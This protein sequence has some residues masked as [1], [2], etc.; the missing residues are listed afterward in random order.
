MPKLLTE[1][2]GTFFLVLTI[3]LAVLGGTLPP[4]IAPIGIAAALVALIYA[5]APVSGAHYNPAVTLAFYL[6]G[7]MTMADVGRYVFAQLSGAAAAA[8]VFELLHPIARPRPQVFDPVAAFG[9]EALFTFALVWV[10]LMV[11]L[12]TVAKDNQYFGLAIGGVVLGGAYAAGPLSGAA[13][14]PA[15]ALGI[16]MLGITPWDLLGLLAGAEVIGGA[17]AALAYRACY[18]PLSLPEAP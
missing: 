15:V 8:I 5:G 14:N 9:A 10:I 1:F 16:T 12:P 17:M 6:S 13:F 3:G 7:R 11:A 18:P 2:I 4:G